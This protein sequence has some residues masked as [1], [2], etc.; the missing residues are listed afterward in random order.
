MDIEAQTEQRRIHT[1]ESGE[2]LQSQTSDI[3]TFMFALA[4]DTDALVYSNLSGTPI[5]GSM[6]LPNRFGEHGTC[7]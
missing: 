4:K 2:S 1:F 3:D 7:E 6:H 5:F